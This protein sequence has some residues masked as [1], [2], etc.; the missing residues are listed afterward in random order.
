MPH[1]C[2]AQLLHTDY[3]SAYFQLAVALMVNSTLCSSLST[4]ESSVLQPEDIPGVAASIVHAANHSV[5]EL[6]Q[7]STLTTIMKRPA[8][9]NKFQ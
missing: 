9:S 1:L 5:E 3:D 8:L 7:R 4:L 2:H 6:L